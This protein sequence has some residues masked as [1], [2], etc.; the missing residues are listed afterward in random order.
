MCL[1]RRRLCCLVRRW[2]GRWRFG[3][4]G[5]GGGGDG[6]RGFLRRCFCFLLR[7]ITFLPQLICVLRGFARGIGQ[8]L[9][10]CGSLGCGGGLLLELVAFFLSGEANGVS[11]LCRFA[12]FIRHAD[13]FG[14]Q[15]RLCRLCLGLFNRLQLLLARGFGGGGGLSGFGGKA[16]F[17]H[18]DFL[19][20]LRFSQRTLLL[21]LLI[22]DLLNGFFCDF[23]RFNGKARFFRRRFLRIF[24]FGFRFF[25]CV[26]FGF[27]RIGVVFSSFL[28]CGNS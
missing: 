22:L 1:S 4:H 19:K 13:F 18:N 6:G 5:H 16:L 2:C 28:G 27:L 10:F 9:G 11:F 24:S 23:P 7:Q 3:W 12:R 14:C 25:L 21:H 8:T 20:F 26:F 15:L 17:F